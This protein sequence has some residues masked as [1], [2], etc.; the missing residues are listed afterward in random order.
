MQI[1]VPILFL[2]YPLLILIIA[3][4]TMKHL[5]QIADTHKA[6]VELNKQIVEQLANI[7]VEL[8]NSNK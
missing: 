8:R 5:S 1:I 3:V 2:L 7:S 4:V 6:M